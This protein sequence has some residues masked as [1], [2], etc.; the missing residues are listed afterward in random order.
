MGMISLKNI[1]SEIPVDAFEPIG[2]FSK[3]ASFRDKRDR[4]LLSNPVTVTK[5]KD[6]F[7]NT[8]VD[9]DFYFVNLQ[10]RRKFAELGLVKE[11]FVFD[12]YPHGLGI[13]REQLKGNGINKDNITVFF[14]G[15]SAAEKTPMT[16]WTIAHRFGHSLRREYAFEELRKWL[17]KQFE[18]ILTMFNKNKPFRT[19]DNWSDVNKFDKIKAHL[20]N[21]IGT[22]RS[23]RLG[24]IK[25]Y[26]EFYYELF[27]QY[28]K[29][30]KVTLNRL[31]NFI[32]TG[33]AAYGRKETA[34]TQKI[35]E[36]NDIIAGI[37]RDFGYYAEDVLGNCVGNIYVM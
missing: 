5:V 30:G 27:A 22:M 4:D 8:S 28:L 29:D 17:E 12:D 33:T 14:V 2:D 36:V 13:K 19:Y 15:N 18:E 31:K 10:G 11:D 34:Y 16:A 1:L 3:G 37:E 32:K 6:F 25:R 21:Q 9:F 26:N 7:K 20:F 24:K 23:A 35:D